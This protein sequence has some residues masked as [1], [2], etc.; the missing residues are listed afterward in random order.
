[1]VSSIESI[2]SFFQA[3]NM[4]DEQVEEL[5]KNLSP[6]PNCIVSDFCLY[7]TSR[8]ASKFNVPRI[9]FH[10]MSCFCLVCSYKVHHSHVL[11][12]ISSE[13]E[14]FP[15]PDLPDHVELTASQLP[16]GRTPEKAEWKE[17]RDQIIDNDLNSYGVLV[18]TF[19]ELE[20]E[21]VKEYKKARRDKVW[22]IGPVSLCN[23]ED[24][25]KAQRGNKSSLD[26]YKCLNWLD[27]WKPSSVL[28]VCLGSLCNLT[29]EQM[30]ELGLGLEASNRPFIWVIRSADRFSELEKWISESGFE[31][32]TKERSLLIRGWA[33]QV[34]ILSHSAIGGFLTHCG[35]NSTLEGITSGVPLLTWPLFGDQ[36]CN[37]KLAVQILKVGIS[38]GAEV[39]MKLGEEDKVG[40]LLKKDDVKKVIERFFDEGEETQQRRERAQQLKK[41]AKSATEE[42]GSSSTNVKLFIQDV[43][44]SELSI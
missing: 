14:Y 35:W 38:M 4:L 41:L 20:P 9:S 36:F 32:R 15:I 22:C 10:G 3:A 13:S 37:E 30:V 12:A 8:I 11:D 6:K 39:P 5:F 43:I 33:P 29:H 27:S 42:G 7:Y 24:I 18:N 21:Y 34:L 1:M 40:V 28:Y 2:F 26:G 23:K 16:F 44:R 31:E 25:D 17:V 19:E